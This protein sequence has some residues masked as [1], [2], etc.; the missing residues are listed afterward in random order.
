[1]FCIWLTRN[2]NYSHHAEKCE[3]SFK[4]IKILARYLIV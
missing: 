3:F 2:L 1:L 4:D